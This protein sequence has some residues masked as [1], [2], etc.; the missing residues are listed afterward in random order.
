MT[1]RQAER[2]FS[3]M[4]KPHQLLTGEHYWEIWTPM[5]SVT[6]HVRLYDKDPKALRDKFDA[7]VGVK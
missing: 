3:R 1:P 7:A 2:Y 4:A 6:P 5:F